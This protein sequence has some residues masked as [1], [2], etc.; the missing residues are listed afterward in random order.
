MSVKKEFLLLKWSIC[1]GGLRMF[2]WKLVIAKFFAVAVFSFSW[3]A[4]KLQHANWKCTLLAFFI[5][6]LRFFNEQITDDLVERFFCNSLRQNWEGQNQPLFFL[7]CLRQAIRN[8]EMTRNFYFFTAFFTHYIR[9]SQTRLLI[10]GAINTTL[11]I[12]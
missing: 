6:F 12:D 10:R 1:L 9:C 8:N 11:R 2:I 7:L 4:V 3:N 5:F